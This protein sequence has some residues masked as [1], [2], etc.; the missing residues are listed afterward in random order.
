ML[1]GQFLEPNTECPMTK[2]QSRCLNTNT[3]KSAFA[4]P[5]IEDARS[6]SVR[7]GS[8]CSLLLCIINTELTVLSAWLTPPPP[9]NI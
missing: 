2:M 6:E 8:G 9:L 3:A 4:V 7:C 1:H 5:H